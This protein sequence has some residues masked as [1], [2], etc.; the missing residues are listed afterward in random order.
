MK[1]FIYWIVLPFLC[2]AC[3]TVGGPPPTVENEADELQVASSF[4]LQTMEKSGV[5][6]LPV[7]SETAPEGIRNETAIEIQVQMMNL[8]PNMALLSATKTMETL[9]AHDATR[10]E[11][12]AWLKSYRL[13]APVDPALLRRVGL[14]TASR[15]LFLVQ[16]DRYQME[17]KPV[18]PLPSLPL[19]GPVKSPSLSRP[20]AYDVLKDIQLTGLLWDIECNKI[21]WEGR[22]R[23]RVIDDGSDERFRMNGLSVMAARNF[24]FVLFRSPTTVSEKGSGC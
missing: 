8:V 4:N 11:L 1:R 15:Y 17:S 3:A 16:V 5:A 14:F 23:V 6:I 12:Q 7:I 24:V 9:R 2:A 21:V 20:V 18:R 19:T 13:G 10:T 22:G